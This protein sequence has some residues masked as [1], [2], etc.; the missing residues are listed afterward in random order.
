M[1]G[2]T[3]RLIDVAIMMRIRRQDHWLPALYT[4]SGKMGTVGV[5]KTWSTPTTGTL[6]GRRPHLAGGNG[7]AAAGWWLRDSSAA[8]ACINDN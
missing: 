2:T 7:D 3:I 8:A 6:P 4:V 1:E 5:K